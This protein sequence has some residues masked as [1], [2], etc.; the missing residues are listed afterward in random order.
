M[1]MLHMVVSLICLIFV[2]SNQLDYKSLRQRCDSL[3]GTTCTCADSSEELKL[4]NEIKQDLVSDA[5]QCKH[6]EERYNVDMEPAIFLTFRTMKS[7]EIVA[8]TGLSFDKINGFFWFN[9]TNDIHESI[10]SRINQVNTNAN[11]S[12]LKFFLTYNRERGPI[13]KAMKCEAKISQYIRVCYYAMDL[14]KPTTK[15]NYKE[16]FQFKKRNLLEIKIVNKISVISN[17]ISTDITT[18]IESISTETKTAWSDKCLYHLWASER[19]KICYVP[20][21]KYFKRTE[22]LHYNLANKM[23][24][25]KSSWRSA[26]IRDRKQISTTRT[27]IESGS[28]LSEWVTFLKANEIAIKHIPILTGLIHIR[29]MGFIWISGNNGSHLNSLDS[30]YDTWVDPTFHPY[31]NTTEIHC[32]RFVIWTH[33]EDNYAHAIPCEYPTNINLVLCEYDMVIH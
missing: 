15:T 17:T 20:V 9:N 19:K 16:H 33:T 10:L 12:C 7:Q 1:K 14:I 11:D 21:V 18:D 22:S 32:H 27:L 25:E 30:T 8:S 24:S 5:Q 3:N 6:L 26:R 29:G 23:C 13:L 4:T 31:F 28:F 2:D